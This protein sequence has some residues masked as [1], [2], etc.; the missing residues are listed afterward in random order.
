L[1]G[2]GGCSILAAVLTP[3]APPRP[4]GPL[5]PSPVDLA[6]TVARNLVPL[7]GILFLGWSATNILILYF[8]DTM[9]AMA[10]MF[11][12]L[13]RHFMPPSAD[14]GLAARLNAEVGCVA[15]ALLLAAVIAIPLGV[16]LLLVGA[17][18]HATWG[19]V[20]GDQSFRI[21]LVLQVIAAF[22]SCLGLYR[23]LSTQTPE[24]LRLKRRFALVFL[25]WGVVL[26]AMYS[27]FLFLFGRFAPLILVAV[28]AGTSIMI[29]VAPD[30][31]LRAMPGGA[32]DADR[33]PGEA[34]ATS[35]AQRKKRRRKR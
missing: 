1:R 20:F 4:A 18:S 11:A 23:A 12:G 10:V 17:A 21:G 7:G 9:L 8:V 32:E 22:W 19:E 31:F 2:G 24:Q 14:D 30:R 29:D 13:M 25:R 35:P 15:G 34:S 33:L 26:M 5:R 6:N 16:P 28:Y 3:A 27:G